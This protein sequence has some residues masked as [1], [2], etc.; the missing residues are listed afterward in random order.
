MKLG[1]KEK[2][3]TIIDGYKVNSVLQREAIKKIL[4]P[5]MTPS[6]AARF[7]R[8]GLQ[9]EIKEQMD[10]V[11][12]DWK[13]F[14][15]NLNQQVK[16][17]IA[18]AKEAVIKALGLDKVQK[19]ADYSQ[20]ISNAIAF[21]K[22][23]ISDLEPSDVAGIIDGKKAA[24]MDD[25]LHFILKDFLGDYDT[26]KSF[27][28][29]IEK[30]IP[31]L[32]GYDGKTI[33]PK[34]FGQFAKIESIMNTLD[35]LDAVAEN[36]FIHKKTDGQEVFRYQGLIYAMPA[37]GYSEEADEQNIIDFATIMDR[38]ADTIDSEGQGSSSEMNE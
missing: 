27:K 17:V 1:L 33:F 34:T 15:M 23:V 8:E 30:K 13:K 24:E 32:C 35:E 4:E 38:L 10:E 11:L 3:Q 19:S 7:T 9:A 37:D 2:I 36:I 12:G 16:N 28:K 25:D 31:Y 6:Y 18:A 14:D 20:R 22:E 5:Y 26:M 29:M 21:V